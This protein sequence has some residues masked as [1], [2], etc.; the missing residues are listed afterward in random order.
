MKKEEVEQLREELE[1]PHRFPIV[2]LDEDNQAYDKLW[3]WLLKGG[4]SEDSSN[5][6]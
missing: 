1:A 6:G 4:Q 5:L 3:D 2:M